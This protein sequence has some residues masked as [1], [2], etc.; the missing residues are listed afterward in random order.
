LAQRS[1]PA[2]IWQTG[3]RGAA[4][5]KEQFEE[6][7]LAKEIRDF[8]N[9]KHW[10]ERNEHHEDFCHDVRSILGRKV[11]NDSSNMFPVN[12]TLDEVFQH[13]ED[14]YQDAERECFVQSGKDEGLAVKS[15]A[16]VK[17]F[18]Y[19]DDLAQHQR[20]DQGVSILEVIYLVFREDQPPVGCESAEE[21]KQERCNDCELSHFN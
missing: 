13:R 15:L 1:R 7:A 16:Q 17:D 2:H 14:Q 11:P 9:R 20:L 6:L 19:K 4:A 18:T 10:D 3:S 21:E 5:L 12:K 8:R